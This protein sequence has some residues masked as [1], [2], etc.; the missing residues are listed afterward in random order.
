[1]IGFW[2]PEVWAPRF[3]FYVLVSFF[4]GSMFPLD[5][6]PEPVF[7]VLKLLP[8]GYLQFFP[9]KIYLG[10]LDFQSIVQGFLITSG[11]IGL[12]YAALMLTWN[13]GIKLY[14]ASGR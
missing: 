5:I 8:F 10:Q 11:W 12:T 7:N 3:I 13:K 9:L 14:S 2:S 6:L 4:A 1:M